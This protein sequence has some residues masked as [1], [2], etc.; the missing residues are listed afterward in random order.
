MEDQTLLVANHRIQSVG[1]SGSVQ[2]PAGAREINLAGH[3]V[4]PGLVGLHDHTFYGGGS[5]PYVHLAFT[6][7]RLYLGAGVTT[8]R[9][10][11][12]TAPYQDLSLKH[13]IDQGESLGP[14]MY[15]TGP[16]ITGA[17]QGHGMMLE[18]STPEAAR[19]VAAYWSEEGASWFKAYAGITR[20]ELGAL[21]DEAHKHGTKVTAH[22][23]SVGYREAVSLGIDDLEHGLFANSEYDPAKKPDVCP[24]LNMALMGSI[25]I[26]SEAVQ[27]T[28]RDMI[29]HH[30]AMTSTL[31]VI[32][33]L[34]PGRPPLEQRVLD[35][36]HPAAREAYLTARKEIESRPSTG[37]PAD[38]FRKLM[39]YEVAF[40]KAG[41]LL[42][43][44]VDPTGI[45]G[46]LPGYGDQR[47]YELLIEAGFAPVQ[48]IQIL[49][50]NGAKVLGAFE[51]YGSITAGKSADLVVIK[52]N[53]LTT[54]AEIRNVVTVFRE[55]VGYDSPKLLESVK[56][57]VGL[58]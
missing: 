2:I 31:A 10:T 15:I 34:V 52:G 41:G 19:R 37:V 22:L 51:Q 33:G 13:S 3:T 21:I 20:A 38:V 47:N 32:E 48:A 4:I 28:F 6:G 8:I 9:T 23:C 55:G 57:L 29:A 16:Y 25:D 18:V 35:A 26:G 56:G 58:K 1:R 40:V 30:V 44:G 17:G 24:P 54:P 50:G 14:R 39:A 12:S 49:T 46:V 7:P 36:L 53:P 43:A 42:A 5:W 11:G 27:A 45:G